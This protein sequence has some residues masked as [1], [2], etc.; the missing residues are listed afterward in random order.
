VSEDT[1][2]GLLYGGL[3]LTAVIFLL[4][5]VP[6]AVFSADAYLTWVKSF[7]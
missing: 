4:L 1:K 6:W 3:V 7:F 2:D 5:A